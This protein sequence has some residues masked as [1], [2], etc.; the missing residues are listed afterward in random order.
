MKKQIIIKDEQG[1]FFN[2]SVLNPLKWFKKEEQEVVMENHAEVV[3]SNEAIEKGVFD[4]FQKKI[5]IIMN[6]KQIGE[7]RRSNCYKKNI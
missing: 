6:G 4:E 1:T 7:P 5:L 3:Y 2:L